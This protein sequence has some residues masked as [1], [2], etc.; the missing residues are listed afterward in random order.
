MRC[1]E[2]RGL[3]ATP[4]APMSRPAQHWRQTFVKNLRCAHEPEW[5]HPCAC[6]S[7]LS[8]LQRRALLLPCRIWGP[9][10]RGARAAV[11]RLRQRRPRSVAAPAGSRR[12]PL[13]PASSRPHRR[14][15]ACQPC[16]RPRGREAPARRRVGRVVRRATYNVVWEA[17]GMYPPAQTVL[18]ELRSP[19]E[20]AANTCPEPLSD[21]P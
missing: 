15:T 20:L 12:E 4:Y 8:Q 7:T 11:Q 13:D 9:R 21:V 1:A 3:Y 16:H 5:R 14:R 6:G 10:Q 19:V 2:T 18:G 17:Q